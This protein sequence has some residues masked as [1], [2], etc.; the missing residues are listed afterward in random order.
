[1]TTP[2][3]QPPNTRK[4]DR[5]LE[6]ASARLAAV[7][8]V[9]PVVWN[10]ETCPADLLPWLGWGL[11]ID[12][13]DP[14][15]PEETKRQMIAQAIERQRRKGSVAAVREVLDA[16][17]VGLSIHEWFNTGLPPYTF[18][19]RLPVEGGE[20]PLASFIEKVADQ[21]VRVKP[22]RAH[23]TVAQTLDLAAE[24]GLLAVG[25]AAAAHRMEMA[26]AADVDWSDHLLTSDG[27]PLFTEDGEPL[28]EEDA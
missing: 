18:E 12:I 22:A 14:A 7:P 10:P 26:E 24:V 3:L 8:V 28:L 20:T 5:A 2:V 17:A 16:F 21:V 11:S 4:G 15:W 1:M 23:F 25:R 9:F 13:W 27:E 6:L 19:V